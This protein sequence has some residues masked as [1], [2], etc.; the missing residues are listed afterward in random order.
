MTHQHQQRKSSER[1]N[2][3]HAATDHEELIRGE[4]PAAAY[5]STNSILKLQRTVGNQAVLRTLNIAPPETT[6][7]RAPK[8]KTAIDIKPVNVTPV[9]SDDK[10]AAEMAQDIMGTQLA[11]LEGWAT[12]L[13]NFDKVMTS[14][15]D[16]SGDPRFSKVLVDFLQDKIVG[17]IVKRA[18]VPV[19]SESYTLVKDAFSLMGKMEAEVKRA[20]A[21]RASASLRDF[22][23][24]YRSTIG[25]LRQIILSTTAD[26][27]AKAR[28]AEDNAGMS[29]TQADAYGML[30]L[31]LADTLGALDQQLK[32]AAPEA[33]YRLLTE[34]WLRDST[35]RLKQ[36]GVK[37]S[38]I[39]IRLEADYTVRDAHINGTGGQK[40]A[41]QLLK[42]SPGGIDP[43]SMKVP[44]F[45]HYFKEGARGAS[46]V[47][48][49]DANGVIDHKNSDGP[50]KT[51]H[52]TLEKRGLK[53]TTKL[54][55]E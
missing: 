17:E 22:Y 44:R 42:D 29:Q 20:D 47:L 43:Y 27:V 10:S 35:V 31:E 16:K 18:K 21:A 30:R 26:F 34:Q 13:D 52:D 41:E 46:T 12:A 25:K 55:G 11:I 53:P 15:A 51:L 19:I 23:V 5:G 36:V 7:Q 45:I 33:I 54:K 50:Y 37:P 28:K 6:V 3:L 1:V 14:E 39:F 24:T 49:V 8:T 9:A 2:L 38:Y 40:L 32:S 48:W 4:S